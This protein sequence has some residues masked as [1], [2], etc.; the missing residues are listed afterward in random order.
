MH[1]LLASTSLSWLLPSAE[2]VGEKNS[3]QMSSLSNATTV[4]HIISQHKNTSLLKDVHR[5]EKCNLL[6]LAAASDRCLFPLRGW[7]SIYSQLMLTPSFTFCVPLCSAV[8]LRYARCL[9][10]PLF[11]RAPFIQLCLPSGFCS[12]GA[13]PFPLNY[14]MAEVKTLKTHSSKPLGYSTETNN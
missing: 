6:P 11:N 3:S 10:A 1:L 5:R 14:T 9:L 4:Q 8:V 12:T 13:S 2:P 7:S